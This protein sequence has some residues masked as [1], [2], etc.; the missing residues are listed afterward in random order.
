VKVNP[1]V[2]IGYSLDGFVA[3]ELNADGPTKKLASPPAPSEVYAITQRF[4]L[5]SK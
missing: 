3:V 1:V 4:L 5:F 2:A